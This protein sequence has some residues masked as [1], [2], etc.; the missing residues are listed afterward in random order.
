[1]PTYPSNTTYDTDAKNDMLQNNVSEASASITIDPTVLSKAASVNPSIQYD[2]E[3]MCI[4][5]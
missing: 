2:S 5:E 4:E 3:G 1:M